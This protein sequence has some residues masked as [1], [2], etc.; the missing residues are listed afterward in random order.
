MN[1]FYLDHNPKIAASYHCDKH[2]VKMILETAQMLC[3]A[4]HMQGINA[5]YKPTHKNHPSSVWARHSRRNFGWLCDLGIALCNEY[6]KRYN[7]V[8]K[9]MQHIQ[10]CIDNMDKLIFNNYAF[11]PPP[12]AMPDEYKLSDAVNAYRLYYCSEKAHF[13]KWSYTS[14][15]NWF[16]KMLEL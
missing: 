1:V 12:L 9:S 2:C 13:A 3:T 11:T 16:I 8:H 7:K 15:P 6:T 4:Y 14:T 5:P 10:W